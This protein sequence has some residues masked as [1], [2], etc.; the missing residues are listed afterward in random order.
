MLVTFSAVS[1]RLSRLHRLSLRRISTQEGDRAPTVFVFR[2]GA[3]TLLNQLLLLKQ[4]EKKKTY[5]SS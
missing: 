1:Y 5:L 4:F 3:L 2:G